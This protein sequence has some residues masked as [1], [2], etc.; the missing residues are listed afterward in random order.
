MKEDDMLGKIGPNKKEK[1]KEKKNKTN[2]L[3][4]FTKD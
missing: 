1:E 2:L 3:S 4:I